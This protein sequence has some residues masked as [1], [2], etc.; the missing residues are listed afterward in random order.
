[1]TG[2]ALLWCACALAVALVW[3]V[4][5]PIRHH[6]TELAPGDQPIDLTAWRPSVVAEFHP[7]ERAG[8]LADPSG[9]LASSRLRPGPSG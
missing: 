7:L 1:V 8:T 3:W 2:V 4:T 6:D 5:A 9:A